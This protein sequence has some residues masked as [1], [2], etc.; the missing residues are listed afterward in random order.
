MNPT[1]SPPRAPLQFARNLREVQ[2]TFAPT[3]PYSEGK[4]GDQIFIGKRCPGWCD[5]ILMTPAAF[6]SLEHDGAIY[7][8]TGEDVCL[9]DHKPVLLV[10]NLRIP[11]R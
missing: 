9:G 7:R 10:G 4:S 6:R 11:R 2:I 8:L 5:R 1:L 3:Y